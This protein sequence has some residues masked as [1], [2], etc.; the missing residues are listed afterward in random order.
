M[1][2]A[3]LGVAAA[4]CM[5]PSLA[6]GN[7][8]SSTRRLQTDPNDYS[9]IACTTDQPTDAFY[10]NSLQ[11]MEQSSCTCGS[12]DQVSPFWHF[13]VLCSTR[14]LS[15]ALCLH[16]RTN[17]KCRTSACQWEWARTGQPP[18]VGYVAQSLKR[19]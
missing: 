10:C 7:S 14:G 19:N 16:C 9:S 3:L 11:G 8:P 13:G 15:G 17:K 4:V 12:C 6:G 2:S 1:P 5:M 18:A